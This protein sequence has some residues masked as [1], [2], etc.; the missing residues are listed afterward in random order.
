MIVT[1]YLLW[2]HNHVICDKDCHIILKYD[3]ILMENKNAI[4][5]D[6]IQYIHCNILQ[7]E[8]S[9]THREKTMPNNAYNAIDVPVLFF[10]CNK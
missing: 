6:Q 4:L 2:N 7:K 10:E 3:R 8:S 5:H 1:R 9:K